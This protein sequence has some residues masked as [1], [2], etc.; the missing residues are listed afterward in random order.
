MREFLRNLNKINS[1][2][3]KLDFIVSM[4]FF[5]LGKIITL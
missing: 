2:F 5:Q 3:N 1:F 4:S